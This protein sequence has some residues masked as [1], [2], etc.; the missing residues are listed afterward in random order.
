MRELLLKA[1]KADVKARTLVHLAY[2][3]FKLDIPFDDKDPS[4]K[5]IDPHS[6][7]L[8]FKSHVEKIEKMKGWSDLPFCFMK[9]ARVK[10]SNAFTLKVLATKVNCSI[11]KTSHANKSCKKTLCKSC[12]DKESTVSKCAAHGKKPVSSPVAGLEAPTEV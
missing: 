5:T 2:K 4:G 7:V 11:C 10:K 8:V 6:E 1:A 12:C 3:S 9:V